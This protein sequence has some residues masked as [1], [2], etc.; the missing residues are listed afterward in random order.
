MPTGA[1][2]RR[3]E[4]S[5]SLERGLRL[6]RAF[7][8][9]DGVLS[10][11]ALAART[12]LPRPTVSRLTRSLVDAGFLTH[13]PRANA[14]GLSAV[15]LSFAKV[16][17]G[18][19]HALRSAVKVMEG[20]AR[21]GG[22]NVGMATRDQDEMVYLDSLRPSVLGRFRK[23]SAGSRV[24]IANTALGRA[25]LAGL[26]RKHRDAVLRALASRHEGEWPSVYKGAQSAFRQVEEKGWC[27]ATWQPE[28][29]SLAAPL[30]MPDGTFVAINVSFLWM[31]REANA[32]VEQHARTLLD[33]AARVRQRWLD[34]AGDDRL[35]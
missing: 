28:M 29:M 33:L 21:L 27:G 31:G 19:A 3:T 9:G 35:D 16:Y 8:L 13:D 22:I 34:D 23:I 5:K 1:F 30:Q 18:Q 4:G 17:S 2:V 26:P 32:L 12:G 7:R 15:H 11:S 6:L 25:Y 24:P 14:Y 20:T 10:N